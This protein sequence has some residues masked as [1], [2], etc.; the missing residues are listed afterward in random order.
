MEFL[1]SYSGLKDRQAKVKEAEGKRLTMLHD[2]F[3][4]G[5][6][7][8]EEP[9]GVMTFTDSPAATTIP[10]SLVMQEIATIKQQVSA[11]Q[12]QVA[13]LSK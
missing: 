4:S 8:G 2:N 1:Y 9:R 13:L 10:D 3:A 5:W 7:H 12:S 6:T 11:M